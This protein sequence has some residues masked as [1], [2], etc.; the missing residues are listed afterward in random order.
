[1]I[2]RAR[3]LDAPKHVEL[4]KKLHPD[5]FITKIEDAFFEKLTTQFCKSCVIKLI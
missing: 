4:E 3:E 5:F 2:A 1:M